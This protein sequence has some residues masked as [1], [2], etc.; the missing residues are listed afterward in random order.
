L[1]PDEEGAEIVQLS[2]EGL[3]TKPQFYGVDYD[4]QI[5]QANQQTHPEAHWFTGDFIQ[6]VKQNIDK[7]RPSLVHFDGTQT[8]KTAVDHVVWVMSLCTLPETMVAANLMLSDGHSSRRYDANEFVRHV[9]TS[10]P[11]WHLKWTVHEQF[12][13]Y[14]GS[15]TDMGLFFFQ[16]L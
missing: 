3:I 11:R 10:I 13:A 2:R 12:F 16:K 9:L 1:Q 5:I 7:F 14:R 8:V 4:G 15:H 6:V